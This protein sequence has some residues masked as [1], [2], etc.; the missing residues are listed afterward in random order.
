MTKTCDRPYALVRRAWR[1]DD[2]VGM[3]VTPPV[4]RQRQ[5]MP[6]RAVMVMVIRVAHGPEEYPTIGIFVSMVLFFI[7]ENLVRSSVP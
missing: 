4:R 3:P 7:L 6:D 1:D 2:A 5:I